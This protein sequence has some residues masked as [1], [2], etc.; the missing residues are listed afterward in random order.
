MAR[1]DAALA[2]A[3]IHGFERRQEVRRGAICVSGAGLEA[4]IFCDIVARLY[5]VGPP[6]GSNDVLPIGL[7]LVT[8]LPEDAPMV[9]AVVER[10]NDRGEPAYPRS[11]RKAT[12]TA[13][14]EAVL[15]NGV[16]LHREVAFV[17]SAPAGPLARALDLQG[18]QELFAARVKRLVIVEG[19]TPQRDAAAL[20]KVLREW[21]SPIVLCGR[22]VGESLA[23][24][25][26]SLTSDFA[27]ASAHP[28]VEAYRAFKPMPYDAP[29]YDL[30]AV[31][32]ASRP[33]SGFFQRSAPGTITVSDAGRLAF[34]PGAGTA[35]S[36]SVEPAMREALLRD[37]VAAAS[38]RPG[39]AA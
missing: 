33:E 23:F 37:L 28:V 38:A 2:L 29:S 5:A 13:L 27:W 26:A 21:P 15:R 14:A 11:I 24:P 6:R 39:S 31:H 3:A 25:A 8:P 20:R 35:V 32:F 16:S 17:L 22:D 12:D 9:R 36:I 18:V 4:A 34:T 1:P 19:S 10:Q 30:A 7:D